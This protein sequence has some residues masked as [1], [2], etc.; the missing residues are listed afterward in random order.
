MDLLNRLIFNKLKYVGI[1]P[2]GT[3]NITENGETDVKEYATA[4]VQVPQPSG[5]IDITANGTVDVTDYASAN[6][7][8]S[9]D[10]IN[11][12]ITSRIT[13]SSASQVAVKIP[14]D[15]SISSKSVS[16]LSLDTTNGGIKIGAGVTQV[17]ISAKLTFFDYQTTG[18][19]DLLIYK[20]STVVCEAYDS[21]KSSGAIVSIVLNPIVLDCTENDEFYLYV[22]KYA[23]NTMTVLNGKSTNMVVEVTGG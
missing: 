5:S 9:D 18:E 4:N 11:A 6:V 20:N 3:I 10:I 2:E 8:V 17:S 19:V 22:K 21:C 16:K 13:N 7:D 14:L 12:N 15:T 23:S 1:E